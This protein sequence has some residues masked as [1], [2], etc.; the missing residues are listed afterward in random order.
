MAVTHYSETQLDRLKP[1]ELLTAYIT[2]AEEDDWAYIERISGFIKE[3]VHKAASKREITDFED[4]EEECVLAVWSKIRALKSG[5]ST[6]QID[7]FEAF[8]RQSVHN[9]YCDAV[10]RKRPKWYNLKIEVMEILNGKSNIKGFAYWEEP[11]TGE[12]VCG[13]E[14]WMGSKRPVTSRCREILDQQERFK[15]KYLNNRQP[16]EIPVYEMIGI[17]LNY[18]NCPVGVDALTN[19]IV[20]LTQAKGVETFSI[21]GMQDDDSESTSGHEW[22][23]SS[24]VDIEKQVTDSNWFGHV[25]TWFWDEFETLSVGQKKAILFGMPGDQVLALCTS[26]GI[27]KVAQGLQ[28]EPRELADIIDRLP[29]PDIEIAEKIGSSARSVPSIRFK[30]WARIRKRTQRSKFVSEI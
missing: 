26:I 9:R 29:I 25:T 23:L 12:K 16:N 30:A 6:T 24:D 3:L 2:M 18:A 4:F 19:C 27:G 22:L 8:I 28:M 15:R 17:I 11:S 5:E 10:R 1:Q 14:N 20:E 13:F 7:N 21:E